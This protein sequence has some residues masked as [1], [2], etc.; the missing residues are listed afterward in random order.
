[1]NVVV[2]NRALETT[3]S[4]TLLYGPRT[5]L[6]NVLKTKFKKIC[7]NNSLAKERLSF[8]L[9][10]GLCKALLVVLFQCLLVLASVKK[11]LK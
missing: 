5:S 10:S 2:K 3:V 7:G 4:R 11:N 8:I 1:M 9:Y 6:M